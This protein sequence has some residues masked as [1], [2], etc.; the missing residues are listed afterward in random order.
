LRSARSAAIERIARRDPACGDS[1]DVWRSRGLAR[2]QQ[3]LRRGQ[4]YLR[5]RSLRLRQVH[6]TSLHQ[7][8][9][10]T[11]SGEIFIE[12]E[13][14]YY[15][16][17]RGAI[18][19]HSESRITTVRRKLGMVFQDFALFPHLTAI[20]NVTEGLV[21]GLGRG[22]QEAV[23]VATRVLARVGLAERA[24]YYPDQLSGGQKQRVAI[25]RSLAMTPKA[26]L[27]DEPTS[28]LDP[29]LV[30]EVL[31]VMQDLSREG[32][33]MIIATHEMKFAREIADEVI[34]VDH[35]VIV[36]EGPPAIVLESPQHERTRNFLRRVMR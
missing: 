26:I 27:F 35:G 21:Y 4:G 32:I 18:R 9:G 22:R 29:E 16:A 20:E 12:G 34:F 5:D 8:I 6:A 2:R 23:A 33:T 36:E 31:D 13:R 1:Q 30:G 14:A 11:T 17:D 19:Y 28:A 3:D 10:K 15:E 24:A 25:A 7:S